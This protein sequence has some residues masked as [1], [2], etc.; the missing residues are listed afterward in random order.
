MNPIKILYRKGCTYARVFCHFPLR[1]VATQSSASGYRS[2]KIHRKTAMSSNGAGIDLPWH[3]EDIESSPSL[4][5]FETFISSDKYEQLKRR[6]PLEESQDEVKPKSQDFL[7]CS[8]SLEDYVYP[9]LPSRSE[10]LRAQPHHSLPVLSQ[11]RDYPDNPH[12]IYSDLV[13][14]SSLHN[15]LVSSSSIQASAIST[16]KQDHE[17]KQLVHVLQKTLPNLSPKQK[18]ASSQ[19]SPRA[20]RLKQRSLHLN[21]ILE[22]RPEFRRHFTFPVK[23]IPPTPI[24]SSKSTKEPTLDE[25]HL[26]PP[27]RAILD[28]LRKRIGHCK[29]NTE[30]KIETESATTVVIPITSQPTSPTVSTSRPTSIPSTAGVVQSSSQSYPTSATGPSMEYIKPTQTYI[31]NSRRASQSSPS[32]S[33]SSSSTLSSPQSRSV[34]SN[35]SSNKLCSLCGCCRCSGLIMRGNRATVE[36]SK[37]T[38]LDCASEQTF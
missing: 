18:S 8:G 14:T 22:G 38:L 36:P 7:H 31:A 11:L 21:T 24:K 17:Q 33:T 2:S 15:L 10:I 32:Y 29:S 1:R 3:L 4:E 20:F 30:P 9:D 35:A 6:C 37:E 25:N 16:L 12:D 34:S 23:V 26:I 28:E 19:V 27:N 5:E 13:Y